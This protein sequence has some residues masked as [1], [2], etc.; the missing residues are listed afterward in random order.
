MGTLAPLYLL[1][2]NQQIK[3]AIAQGKDGEIQEFEDE[4]VKN[5]LAE[6]LFVRYEAEFDQKV[7]EKILT[8]VRGLL[9]NGFPAEAIANAFGLS[10]DT[11]NNAQLQKAPSK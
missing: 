10:I 4:G 6:K 7:E 3:K 9:A 2:L 8:A 1:K 5:M 11:V